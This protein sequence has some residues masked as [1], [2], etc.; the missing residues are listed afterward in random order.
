[1]CTHDE[2]HDF[3]KFSLEGEG[4]DSTSIPNEN[5]PFDLDTL[6]NLE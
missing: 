2:G 6:K 1:M 4:K 3:T 5:K